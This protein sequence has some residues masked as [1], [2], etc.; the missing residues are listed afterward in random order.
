MPLGV[1]V[2][3]CV[4]ASVAGYVCVQAL[5]VC[6][7]VCVCQHCV[8]VCVCAR[9]RSQTLCV[10]VH[11]LCVRMYVYVDQLLYKHVRMLACVCI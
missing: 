10:H 2:C 4:H 5:H 7:L 8:Y 1:C 11:V 9:V 6:V 3:A